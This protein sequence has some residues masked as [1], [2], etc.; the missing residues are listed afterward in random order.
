[1]PDKSPFETILEAAQRIF[2]TIEMGLRKLLS[3]RGGGG[4]GGDGKENNGKS[5]PG[6]DDPVEI[7]TKDKSQKVPRCVRDEMSAEIVDSL[8]R[9]H[10]LGIANKD[11]DKLSREE[12]EAY[13]TEW[14]SLSDQERKKRLDDFK[15]QAAEKVGQAWH[16][17]NVRTKSNLQYTQAVFSDAAGVN[18][19]M[20]FPEADRVNTSSQ[21]FNGRRNEQNMQQMNAQMNQMYQHQAQQVYQQGPQQTMQQQYYQAQPQQTMQQQYYQ[22]QPQQTMQQRVNQANLQQNPNTAQKN[23][24]QDELDRE[25]F[26]N[27]VQE[28]ADRRRQK[29]TEQYRAK[30]SEIKLNNENRAM[31]NDRQMVPNNNRQ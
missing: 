10:A 21:S 26:R 29:T 27:R 16:G 23:G 30:Q 20:G 17:Y 1:M 7:G 8:G 22:A 24:L 31:N 18:Y 28:G 25:N 9:K 13:K 12:K 2:D 6:P 15:K 11:W 19:H 3:G 5:K 4:A 14:I